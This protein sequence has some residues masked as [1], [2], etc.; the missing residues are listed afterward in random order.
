MTSVPWDVNLRRA[1]TSADRAH[2]EA[3]AER[4]LRRG[5]LDEALACLL[6]GASTV[7]IYSGL[8]YE[9]P[10]IAAAIARELSELLAAEGLVLSSL[11]GT[12]NPPA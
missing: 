7:Q 3:R 12:A 4:C 6:A 10:G 1:M 11:V 5:E 2:L 9:G 8:V